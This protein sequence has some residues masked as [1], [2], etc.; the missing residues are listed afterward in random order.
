[1]MHLC[2]EVTQGRGMD[3]IKPITVQ[4]IQ[5]AMHRHVMGSTRKLGLYRNMDRPT[6]RPPFLAT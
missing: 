2:P 3:G 6:R 4:E 5:E 1:M